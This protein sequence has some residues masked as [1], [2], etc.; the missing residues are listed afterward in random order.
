M[1]SN[2]NH[3]SKFLIQRLNKYINPLPARQKEINFEQD[4]IE[5]KIIVISPPGYSIDQIQ[6]RLNDALIEASYEDDLTAVKFLLEKGASPNYY[7]VKT[8]E[9]A[10]LYHIPSTPLQNAALNKNS[11]MAQALVN[12][13]AD[14]N[15]HS[16]LFGTQVRD[17]FEFK[18]HW[19]S[20]GLTVTLKPK[21]LE[22]SKDQLSILDAPSL[23]ANS[24]NLPRVKR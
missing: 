24:D 8:G 21:N 17:T 1:K 10:H 22:K 2:A 23:T 14:I 9:L 3:E 16:G 7:Q 5:A 15:F 19:F 6:E 20:S 13:K 4:S 11:E 18:K 12:A